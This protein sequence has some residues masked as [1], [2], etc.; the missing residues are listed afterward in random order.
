[1]FYSDTNETKANLNVSDIF[2][3]N[4]AGILVQNGTQGLSVTEVAGDNNSILITGLQEGWAYSVSTSVDRAFSAIQ[5]TGAAGTSTFKLGSFSY[6]E[7]KD[8]API[9]LAYSYNFV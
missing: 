9:E 2:I 6:F 4:A 8:A 3:Y 5:V 7:I 1:M